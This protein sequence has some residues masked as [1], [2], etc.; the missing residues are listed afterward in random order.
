MDGTDTAE[1]NDSRL[2][3]LRG[4]SVETIYSGNCGRLSPA[5]G[6]CCWVLTVMT[7]TACL[8]FLCSRST[9]QKLL[10]ILDGAENC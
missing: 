3:M 10:A 2:S 6:C 1:E 8:F 9:L 5:G 4:G 7:Q